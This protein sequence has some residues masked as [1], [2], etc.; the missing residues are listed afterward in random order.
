MVYMSVLAGGWTKMEEFKNERES[1][2]EQWIRVHFI[3]MKFLLMIKRYNC[4]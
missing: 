3:N 1:K 4:N 2:F